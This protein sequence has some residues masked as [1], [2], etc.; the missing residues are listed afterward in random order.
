M[1]RQS[2]SLALLAV[3]LLCGFKTGHAVN[4]APFFTADMNQH[5]LKENTPVGSVVYQLQGE[6]PEGSPVTYGIEG[7]KKL[8]VDP[9]TG[10]VTVAEEIDRESDNMRDLGLSDNEI[11]LTV[12]ITDRVSEGEGNPNVV[13]VPISVIVLDE[14]DNEPVFRGTP[15][16][17]SLNEDT[18]V[19]TTIFR[20]IEATDSDLIGEVLEVTCVPREGYIDLCDYFDI[21][22]RRRETDHDMFR[23]SVVLKRPLDY[24]ERQIYQIPIEVFDGVHTVASDITFT[25]N[26]V[27]NSPPVFTGSLTGIVN[28][29]DSIGTPV[30][31]VQA[32]D[33]DTG[34]PRRIIYDLVKNPNSY[35]V[36]DTNT[37]QITVDRQLDRESLSS[38]SGVLMLQV[39]ASEL[40]NG[41]PGEDETT[42]ATADIT[43]TIRDVNDEAPTFN[44]Q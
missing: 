29:D 1:G 44:K 19:G 17:S 27:Q 2:R 35:F 9:N 31:K 21:V 4:L 28:E 15:Y 25:I 26:D 16:K 11:R 8:Q 22:P 43:I 42:S 12:T 37:G 24:R 39:R 38:S 7:T 3:A 30:L 5:T 20:A 32:K 6:D 33:G 13:R 10:S 23:G 18:P 14:N 36:I 40:V 41:V 34:N